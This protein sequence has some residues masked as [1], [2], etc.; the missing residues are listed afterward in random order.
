MSLMTRRQLIDRGFAAMLAAGG[1]LATALLPGNAFSQT[2]TLESLVL[3]AGEAMPKRYTS[4]GKNISP[5][6]TWRN[7]PTNT[8]EL[9]L[10]F[11]DI[12]EPRVHWLIYRIPASLLGL[13]EGLPQEE[14]VTHPPKLS[15]LIHG[16]TDYK[17][18]GIGYRAPVLLP[19]NG[20]RFRFTLYALNAKLGLL[21][22]LD[23]AS[24]MA[25]IKNHII[26][27]GQLLVTNGR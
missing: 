21:P 15:G 10:I 6:L 3:K 16:L 12:D 8:A 18:G 11:E 2:I 24:L 9:A 23:K 17:Q 4:S 22:G 1:V 5:P 19:G 13:P 14:V 7:L 26:A 20:H 25:L 27:E